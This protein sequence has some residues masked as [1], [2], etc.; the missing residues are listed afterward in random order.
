MRRSQWMRRWHAVWYKLRRGYPSIQERRARVD[1]HLGKKLAAL[2]ARNT[3]LTPTQLAW[4]RWGG[5][6]QNWF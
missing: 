6:A 2:P 4:V 3:G 5:R 1:Q